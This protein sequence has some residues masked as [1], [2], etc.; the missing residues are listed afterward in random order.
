MATPAQREVA[1][2]EAQAALMQ[3]RFKGVITDGDQRDAWPRLGVCRGD[4]SVIE[5]VPPEVDKA[6]T[7]LG[8]IYLTTG[9]LLNSSIGQVYPMLRHLT[10]D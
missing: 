7:I 4:G 6:L 2:K 3:L 10:H 5:G 9:M 8:G 1:L